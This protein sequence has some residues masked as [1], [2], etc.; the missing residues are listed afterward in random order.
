M[1]S[2]ESV[3]TRSVLLCVVASGPGRFAPIRLRLICAASRRQGGIWPRSQL[4]GRRWES[5]SLI[6]STSTRSGRICHTGDAKKGG[7]IA[8]QGAL[9]KNA[10]RDGG[11]EIGGRRT[12]ETAAKSRRCSSQ[13]QFDPSSPAGPRFRVRGTSGKTTKAA[14]AN[15]E[16][17]ENP[18]RK[19]RH[20]LR[21]PEYVRAR[22]APE[23]SDY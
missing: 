6:K 8:S 23:S 4:R 15:V 17:R 9:G 19:A 20:P 18:S 2:G 7:R 14:K 10:G 3:M 21:C 12:F 13:R 16:V 1:I 5:Q 11:F 22:C